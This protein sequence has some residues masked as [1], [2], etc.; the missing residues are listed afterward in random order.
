MNK[1]E[2]MDIDEAIEQVMERMKVSRDEALA[3]ITEATFNGELPAYT[4]LDDG[5]LRRIP[6]D[7]LVKR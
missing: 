6:P 3:M 2:M 5:F 4:E 1:E 7:E